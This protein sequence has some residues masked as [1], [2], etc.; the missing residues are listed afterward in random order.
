[1]LLDL[2]T[3]K[4]LQESK[5]YIEREVHIEK[6]RHKTPEGIRAT[7]STICPNSCPRMAHLTQKIKIQ[8]ISKIKKTFKK[9]FSDCLTFFET[10]ALTDSAKFAKT[11]FSK[12]ESTAKWLQIE[13][14]K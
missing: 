5:L 11:K 3:L 7:D 8:S 6:R 12:H 13:Q 9:S 14:R 1:M 4:L 10:L 2:F